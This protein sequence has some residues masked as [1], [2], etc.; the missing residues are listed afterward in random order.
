MFATIHYT[1]FFLAFQL[2]FTPLL[3]PAASIHIVPSFFINGDIERQTTTDELLVSLRVPNNYSI[4]AIDAVG[5][6]SVETQLVL[7]DTSSCNFPMT[8]DDHL[9]IQKGTPVTFNALDNDTGNDLQV[10]A[11]SEPDNGSL[12]WQP[13]GTIN[14]QPNADFTGTEVLSYEITAQGELKATGFV[15]IVVADI[16]AC[17]LVVDRDCSQALETGEYTLTLVVCGGVAPYFVSGSIYSAGVLEGDTLTVKIDD[18]T[19]YFFTIIDAAGKERTI[20]ESH[21]IP[22]SL[23]PDPVLLLDYMGEVLE[24]GNRIQWITAY[25]TRND[26][27]ILEYSPYPNNIPFTAIA[28]LEGQGSNSELATYQF[29]HEEAGVGTHYYQLKSVAQNGKVENQGVVVLVRERSIEI[30]STTL[31]AYPNLTTGLTSIG[32]I[33]TTAQSSTLAIYNS[34]GQLVTKEMLAIR[35]GLNQIPLNITPYT[36]GIYIVAIE[37]E[38]GPITTK[39]I[40]VD[41]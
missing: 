5:C 17:D 35:E 16:K 13:D 23:F 21:A 22:C 19:G 12:H 2:L 37:L 18:G 15:V 14:Y 39:I 27:F 34:V 30:D 38:G 33:A 6:T 26:F 32:F 9:T 11:V 4:T 3:V 20:T 8:I 24:E 41:K 25:E 10:T 40:R 31:K 7:S 1:I 36:N 29:L 28:E